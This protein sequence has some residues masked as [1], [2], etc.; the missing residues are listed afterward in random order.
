MVDQDAHMDFIG[1]GPEIALYLEWLNRSDSPWILYFH[2][3]FSDQDKKGGIGKT[4]LLRKCAELTRQLYPDKVIVTIDFFNVADRNGIVIAERVINQLKSVHPQ[5]YPAASEAILAEYRNMGNDDADS[6]DLQKK[7]A[8]AIESD[9]SA[10]DEQLPKG[11]RH[12]LIFY[13]TF[14]LIEQD[15]AVALLNLA[16]KFPD[17]YQF[18]QIGVVM[19]GRN[20][21]NSYWYGRE[22]EVHEV[23]L[24]P[25]SLAEMVSYIN[26]RPGL[27]TQIADSKA[28]EILYERTEGRPILVGLVT[29]I[30]NNHILPLE[31]ILRVSS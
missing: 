6:I 18:A 30:I 31:S 14:E 9:L 8:N 4:W 5:W 17:N 13:D 3:K 29:D 21:L 1:R 26:K 22:R 12:L 16:Q 24:G 20:T 15:P 27:T 2:D 11:N 7:L 19:A 25:F 28:M 23:A 10:L